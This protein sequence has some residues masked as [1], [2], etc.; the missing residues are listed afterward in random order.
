M[1][2][3]YIIPLLFGFSLVPDNP[4]PKRFE[5]E[6]AAFDSINLVNAPTKDSFV[7][8]GSSSIRMWHTLKEDFKDYLVLNRGF[9]GSQLSDAIYYFERVIL[10]LN[11]A[12]IILYEGDN[13]LASG[14]T[15]EEVLSDLNT[16]YQLVRKQ[17]PDSEIGVIAAKPS[18]S[19][20]NLK[21]KFEKTNQ[22]MDMFC[23]GNE[24]VSF[25]DVYTPMLKDGRPDPELFIQDS[26]HMSLKGYRIWA[27]TVKPFIEK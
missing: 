13:D 25:I 18:P 27:E 4:D 22:M 8:Y 17:L 10:P 9:G 5:S 24:R 14:K 7:F 15:P 21:D 16:F 11:P 1:I 12:K 3:K 23:R 20:W 2:I 19:R 6:I 26:L